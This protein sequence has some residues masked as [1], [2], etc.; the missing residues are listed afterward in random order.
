[1]LRFKQLHYGTLFTQ[2]GRGKH[3]I[4]KKK[5]QQG[6]AIGITGTDYPDPTDIDYLKEEG[7]KTM[8]KHIKEMHKVLINQPEENMKIENSIY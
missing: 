3:Y 2:G 6:G 8:I 1:M 4:H 7:T 5:K